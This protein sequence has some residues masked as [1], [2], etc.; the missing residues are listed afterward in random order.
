MDRGAITPREPR[1]E[2]GQPGLFGGR[3]IDHGHSDL[4]DLHFLYPFRLQGGTVSQGSADLAIAMQEIE[5][6]NERAAGIGAVVAPIAL[7]ISVRVSS[8]K[9]I[10][11][12]GLT[13]HFLYPFRLPG[14]GTPAPVPLL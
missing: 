7:A 10:A 14:A 5:E 2:S 11:D 9:C 12:L 13:C 3:V 1:G 4:F 6:I 8:P